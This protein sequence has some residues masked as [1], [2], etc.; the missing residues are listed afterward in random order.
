MRPDTGLSRLNNSSNFLP[1]SSGNI[2]QTLVN[3]TV[4]ICLNSQG[5]RGPRCLPAQYSKAFFVLWL[6]LAAVVVHL[7]SLFHPF[8]CG[9][10]AV[11]DRLLQPEKTRSW[12]PTLRVLSSPIR[13]L[14]A[15]T[16]AFHTNLLSP[17]GGQSAQLS[18][19]LALSFCFAVDENTKC[20]CG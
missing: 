17:C 20:T 8:D 15:I 2:A 7:S 1:S 4:P 11:T 13:T 14:F 12:H 6:A 18:Q 10:G 16:K 19:P 9:A 3:Q 5:G